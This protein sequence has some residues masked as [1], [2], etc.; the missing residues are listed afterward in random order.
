MDHKTD[1]DFYRIDKKIFWIK[2]KQPLSDISKT[3]FFYESDDSSK[4]LFAVESISLILFN[5]FTSLAPGS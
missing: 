3:A 1:A 5:W 4:F 2:N